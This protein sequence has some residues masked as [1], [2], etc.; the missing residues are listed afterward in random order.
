MY[1][2]LYNV[3]NTQPSDLKTFRALAILHNYIFLY[4]YYTYYNLHRDR[5]GTHHTVI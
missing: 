1:S 3:S 4:T 5:T 2:Y